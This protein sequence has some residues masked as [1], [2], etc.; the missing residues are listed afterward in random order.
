MCEREIAQRLPFRRAA[1][2]LHELRAATDQQ[3]GAV[4]P[5]HIFAAFRQRDQRVGFSRHRIEP[6][7]IPRGTALLHVAH[8]RRAGNTMQR[9]ADV[10]GNDIAG[11]LFTSHTGSSE[12]KRSGRA[13]HEH[14][15]RA[16]VGLC[17]ITNRLDGRKQNRRGRAIGCELGQPLRRIR[18]HANNRDRR[19]VQ[20]RERGILAFRLRGSEWHGESRAEVVAV[21]VA[22]SVAPV[23]GEVQRA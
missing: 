23:R 18:L 5:S 10:A 2:P 17:E 16:V 11:G 19:A 15:P 20:C 6:H 7:D 13:E 3:R 21:D 12:L 14:R 8:L 22:L 9:T 4:H 1:P